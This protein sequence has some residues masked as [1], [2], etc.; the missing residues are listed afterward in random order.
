MV[1]LTPSQRTVFD[2][3]KTFLRKDNT[4]DIFILKGYAGTGKTTMIEFIISHLTG[5]HL[6]YALMA[7]TGRAAKVMRQKLKTEGACTIHRGIYKSELSCKEIENPDTSEKS[8]E[9]FFP[10]VEQ[11]S[12]TYALIIDESS[13][14]SDVETCTEF[15]KF[16]SG[17]L[18]TDILQYVRVTGIKK[19]IFVGDGAQ[20]PPV[21]D[22]DSKAFNESYLTGMGFKV[23]QAELTEVMR[24][25]GDS[26]ILAVANGIRELLDVPRNERYEFKINGNDSDIVEVPP[27]ELAERYVEEFPHPDT[28]NG[29]IINFSNSQCHTQNLLIREKYYPGM[30]GIQEGETL[31]VTSNNYKTFGLPFFNGDMVSV[32]KVGEVINRLNIPVTINKERRHIDLSFQKLDIVNSSTGSDIITPVVVC[33]NALDSD[34]PDLTVWETRALYIDFILRNP[35]L[36]EG[37]LEFKDALKNDLLFNS[38][39]V[40]YGYAIT[41]HKSQGGEWERVFVD[42]SGRI[43][44]DDNVLRWCYTATTRASKT[45]F[46]SNAPKLDSFSRIKVGQ[47]TKSSKT[48]KGFWGTLP[49]VETPFHNA[50]CPVPIKLKTIAIMKA[51]KG[52]RYSLMNVVSMNYQE[53]YKFL[54]GEGQTIALRAKYDGGMTFSPIDLAG[55]GS[56]RDYLIDVINKAKQDPGEI[57]YHPSTEPLRNMWEVM[58]TICKMDEIDVKIVNVVEDLINYKVVYSLLTDA[59]FAS[60]TFYITGGKFTS[61][62]SLSEQ[63]AEDGKLK[64]ILFL[65]G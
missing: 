32:H 6:D 29:V 12:E 51:L 62:M 49:Q 45:L 35:G 56:D 26:K 18:L 19:L 1:E 59:Q 14:I 47:T 34:D 10:L 5:L 41:C 52:T 33:I 61:V 38:L 15:L 53:E 36:K 54:T 27:V 40:K 24:Q 58:S 50:S 31:L 16:G 22:K 23:E 64:K 13:M 39:H 63:G 60:I 43:G 3:I 65:L 30:K 46:I 9:F 4:S 2:K 42:Y 57:D 7:P 20:L 37:S 44:L 28:I 21:S 25:Q 17:K 11:P 48:P 55:D 8:F